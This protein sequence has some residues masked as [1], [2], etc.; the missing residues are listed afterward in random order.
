MQGMSS[1]FSEHESFLLLLPF[2]QK[3]EKIL[4]KDKYVSK[5]G[6]MAVP[7]LQG[8]VGAIALEFG[9]SALS[10]YQLV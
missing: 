1:K 9:A 8:G 10:R 6:K 4:N 2:D 3:D 7:A 5:L